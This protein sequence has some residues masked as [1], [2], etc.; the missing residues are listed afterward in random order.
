MQR[1]LFFFLLLYCNSLSANIPIQYD[2]IE[3]ILFLSNKWLIVI[4]NNLPDVVDEIDKLSDNKFKQAIEKEKAIERQKGNPWP[5]RKEIDSIRKRHLVQARENAGERLLDDPHYFSIQSPTD[6]QYQSVKRPL[7]CTRFITSMGSKKVRGMHDVHYVHYS[8]LELPLNLENDQEYKIQLW[9]G[10]SATFT[11]HDQK[12]LSRSIKINQVGYLPEQKEKFAYLGAYLHEFGALD[13]SQHKTFY[14]CDAKSHKPVLKGA[15]QLRSKNQKITNNKNNPQQIPVDITGEDV[16]SLDFSPLKKEG[17]F[18]LY[19]PGVGRSWNFK[20]S[21]DVYGEVFYHSTRSL[22]HQ[23]CG[24]EIQKPYT[25]WPRDL[26][27][28]KPL[29]ENEHIPFHHYE[30]QP[31]GYERFD[32]IGATTKRFP[33]HPPVAGGWHDAADWDRNIFH[34]TVIFD[35]LYLYEI[36]PQKFRDQQLNIPESGNGI[37]DILDEA[38]YGLNIW[39]ASM[40]AKG[41]VSGFVETWTHPKMHDSSVRYGYSKR[42]RWSS[43]LFATAA[44]QYATL[45]KPFDLEQSIEYQNLALKAYEYGSNP[46]N[47]LG[48]TSI[49]ARKNRGKGTQYSI[50]WT[51]KEEN[52]NT[53]LIH[54]QLRLFILNKDK[55]YLEKAYTLLENAPKPYEWPFT[56]RDLSPWIY[57]SLF[58]I[59]GD[60]SHQAIASRWSQHYLKPAKELQ[61]YSQEQAYRQSW[62]WQQNYWMSWGATCFSNQARVLLLAHT[63]SPKAGF[64]DTAV[65]NLDY[66][67]GSNPLGISWTTGLGSHYPIEIQHEVSETDGI[68]DPVPGISIYGVTE[69]VFNS[70]KELAWSNT[71]PSG[72]RVSFIPAKS[73]EI[74]VWRRWFAHPSLNTNQCEFT[75]H[76]TISPLIF[77]SGFLMPDDWMPTD[78][79]MKYSPQDTWIT[80]E[81]QWYCP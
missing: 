29:L 64:Q 76:E 46:N 57:Y 63:L 40:D 69:G 52:L 56:F 66:Q 12:A 79:L 19:V 34:Y 44:A 24:I 2:G 36:H 33:E 61:R 18:Y 5:T 80:E 21:K 71:S 14:I 41:G 77:S 67:L 26:C 8:Y 53:Y 39:A 75:I 81:G 13:F 30:K 23:R 25:N 58:L 54:A 15:I 48:T 10:R 31:K 65:L 45:I 68:I 9:D 1:F 35:L 38:H 20:H 27:H 7:R 4:T 55:D 78:K 59:E 49:S 11:Y 62:P 42:T 16:Y 47:S 32:V 37:P 22:Y 28:Q 6:P 50:N 17:E 60:W 3:K 70:L 74:P 43:L 72:K 51:E 73:W